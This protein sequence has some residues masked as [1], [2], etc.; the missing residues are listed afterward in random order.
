MA[1][2]VDMRGISLEFIGAMCSNFRKY[3]LAITQQKVA[4]NCSVSRE[5]VS[6]FE[7][8]KLSNSVIFLY[9]IKCGLFD[10]MPIENWNGWSAYNTKA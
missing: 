4:D 5:L 9:Y 6:K 7:G 2:S 1:N 3:K 10:W 8:G